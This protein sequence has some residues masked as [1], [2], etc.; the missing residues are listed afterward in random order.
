MKDFLI[1]ILLLAGPW[2]MACPEITG[3]YDCKTRSGDNTKISTSIENGVYTYTVDDY[4]FIADGEEY[5]D[6]YGWTDWTTK[7]MCHGSVFEWNVE[8]HYRRYGSGPYRIDNVKYI[9]EKVEQKL[10]F[11]KSWHVID[12]DKG[13]E[14]EGEVTVD[15]PLIQ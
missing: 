13:E 2:A 11:Q 8:T 7:A 3:E 15:C 9:F 12:Y 1:F 14:F 10:V 4:K 6:S 5:S